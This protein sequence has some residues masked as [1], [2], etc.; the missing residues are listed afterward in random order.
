MMS[1]DIFF[2]KLQHAVR[3]LATEKWSFR[4]I[5]GKIAGLSTLHEKRVV[6]NS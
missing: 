5:A 2:D 6:L 3:Y 1:F 4:Q